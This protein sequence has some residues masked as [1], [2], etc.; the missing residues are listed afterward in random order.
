MGHRSRR[1]CNRS[2]SIRL[3]ILLS[4]HPTAWTYNLFVIGRLF[5]AG[6][7]TFFF[8]QL[9]LGYAPS[10]FSAIT[11]M[12]T[13]YFIL[14]LGMPHVSVE[15]L[16]PGMFLALELLLRK[17]SWQAVA[18]TS[19]V[20]FLCITGGMPESCFLIVSF[21]CL[22]FLFRLLLASDF[23]ELRLQRLIKLALGLTLG[24][25]LAAFLL[26]PFLE[27]MRIAHDAHQAVNLRGAIT[28]IAIDDDWRT[29]ITYL[30]PGIFGRIFDSIFGGGWTGM[31]SYWGI[32]PI[33]FASGAVLRL[34]SKSYSAANPLRSLTVFFFVSLVLM[35]LKRFGSP[36][37]N[38]I[39]R[40]P[41]AD[42]I[43]F[44]K[45]DEPLMAFCIAMLAGI[46]FSLFLRSRI[47]LRP[48]LCSNAPGPRLNTWIG[49]LVLATRARAQ[50][51]V[52]YLLL[53]PD[54][55]HD[56]YSCRAFAIWLLN[57]VPPSGMAA[58]G[59]SWIAFVGAVLQFHLSE[60]L[61]P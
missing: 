47:R 41:V 21:G 31:R 53:G 58:V 20:T 24:F 29:T 16:L 4:L 28:G 55:W 49:G 14:Y 9:F 42:L 57:P 19:G 18:G 34:T 50:R 46:G 36:L 54:R 48:L 3:T 12:L 43:I 1:P 27:Y 39:G 40:L 22:Y 25:G 51:H 59:I 32:L 37:V 33:I 60:L 7:L 11:F 23:S 44:V 38:W 26:A 56:G 35:L 45:Y 8:A 52:V 61:R 15:V 17:N 13:G 6:L 10:L 5:L 2:P 30:L